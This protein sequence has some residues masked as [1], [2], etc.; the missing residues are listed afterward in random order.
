LAVMKP[1]PITANSSRIRA[2]Q[3]LR[4]LMVPARRHDFAVIP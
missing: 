3:L 4:N 2:F 1:G